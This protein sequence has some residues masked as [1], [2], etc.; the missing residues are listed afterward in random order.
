[1]HKPH[2]TEYLIKLTLLYFI[3]IMSLIKSMGI[4]LNFVVTG[5]GRM[6]E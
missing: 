6:E 5:I 2:F 4:Y 3:I 1:M